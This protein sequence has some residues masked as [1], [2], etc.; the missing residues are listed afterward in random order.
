MKLLVATLLFLLIGSSV[1]GDTAL[2]TPITPFDQYGAIRWEDE[3]PRLDNFAIQ[4]QRDERSLGYIFVYDNI[5][6]CPGEAVARGIRAKRYLTEYRKVPWNQVIWRREGSREGLG[7]TLMIA[8]TR[9]TVLAYP[10]GVVT[11]T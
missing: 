11:K 6:G 4:L 10:F 8:S 2:T 5:G 7:T 1:W 9:S 3:K